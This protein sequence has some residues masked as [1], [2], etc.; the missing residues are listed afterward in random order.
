MQQE[1]ACWERQEVGAR[2]V[3]STRCDHFHGMSRLYTKLQIKW[4]YSKEH[5]MVIEMEMIVKPKIPKKC[6]A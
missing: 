3:H 1:K 5:K 2:E 4:M 6:P